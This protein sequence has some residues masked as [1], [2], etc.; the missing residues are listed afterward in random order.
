FGV[1]AGIEPE[2]HRRFEERFGFPLIEVW[3]MSEVAIATADQHEPRR[4]E[5]RSIGRPLSGIELQ[6][7][8]EHDEPVPVGGEGELLV[9]RAG[10]DPRRGLVREYLNEP[11]VTARAWR[12]GWF[13]T[14]DVVR[15]EADGSYTFVDRQKHMIRRSG[16][17]IAAA[18]VEACLARHSAVAQVACVAAPDE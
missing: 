4:I 18:E 13:H 15:R 3:G 17:N 11:E 1:G 14:G 5:A 16:Q 6:V 9:R 8:D 7:V 2:Q 10:P 12:G